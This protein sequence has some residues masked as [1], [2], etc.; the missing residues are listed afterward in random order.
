MSIMWIHIKTFVFIFI[1]AHVYLL[2]LYNQRDQYTSTRVELD[3]G[4]ESI[5]R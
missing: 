2:N 5:T 3:D 4:Q 1:H